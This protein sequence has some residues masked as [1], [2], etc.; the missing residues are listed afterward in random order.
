MGNANTLRSVDKN[1]GFCYTLFLDFQP[2][3]GAMKFAF[4]C[5]LL[6]L[7]LPLSWAHP[8]GAQHPVATAD[9]T[10]IDPDRQD[11]PVPCDIYYPVSVPADEGIPVVAIGHG[12]LMGSNLYQW[13]GERLAAA[14]YIAAVPR[15]GGELFPD[16]AVFAADLAFVTR[17][18][19]Q[20]GQDE[21]SVLY[22]LPADRRAV[23]G[24][25]MGGGASLLAAAGDPGIQ[26]VANLA[27]AET[28]PSTIAACAELDCA[29]LLLA[30]G[31]DCVTPP[32]GH[33]IPMYE[34]LTAPWRTL[35]ILDGASHCQFAAD[36]FTCSLGESCSPDITRELQWDRTWFLLEPWLDTVLKLD[37]AARITFG[38][39]VAEAGAWADI[40]QAGVPSST[41]PAASLLT[42]GAYPNPFNPR[43]TFAFD[44][45]ASGDVSLEVFDLA[46]RRVARPV[47][48]FRT[49]GRHEAVW[50]GTDDAG[51]ALPSGHYLARLQTPGGRAAV[52]LVITK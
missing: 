43:T 38:Q 29:A 16:H 17:A 32:A 36:S 7:M 31:N 24:H 48:G 13:L 50:D 51:R 41:P 35:A 19:V 34:A 25:S 9:L 1:R 18:V 2:W 14:G 52:K 22:G 33:Q 15:T 11:R 30:G 3:K 26:A 27:A 23:S 49:E 10:F 44:L 21:G 45:P 39:R 47:A 42:L 37:A 40:Q 28:N 46:G 20:A 4:A 5:L 8:A 12:Y 6:I